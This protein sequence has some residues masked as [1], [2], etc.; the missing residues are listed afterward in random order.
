MDRAV[1]Y[2]GL[3]RGFLLALTVEGL[4]PH[5]IDNSVAYIGGRLKKLKLA[6]VAAEQG[7]KAAISHPARS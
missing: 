1:G 4:R 2:S 6:I 3:I 5:I 7:Q